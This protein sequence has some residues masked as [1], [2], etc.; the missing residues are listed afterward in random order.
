MIKPTAK[1]TEDESQRN[2]E[3]RKWRQ[4]LMNAAYVIFLGNLLIAFW[5]DSE[6]KLGLR[7][8]PNLSVVLTIVGFAVAVFLGGL[9]LYYHD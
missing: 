9:S 4:V 1:V 2:A 7:T 3:R 6:A 5:L 8:P